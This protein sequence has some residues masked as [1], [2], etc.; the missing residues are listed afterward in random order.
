MI[1]KVNEELAS[2]IERQKMPSRT[3]KINMGTDSMG[4]HCDGLEAVKQAAYKAL[5][6]ERYDFLIYSW[7]YGAELKDLFGQQLTYVYA[8]VK[9]RIEEALLQDDRIQKV[10]DFAYEKTARDTLH[11]TFHVESSEGNFES[12]LSINV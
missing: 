7:N 3:Y 8:E 1:P 11:I 5:H 2:T 4:G 6:T 10:S 12:E 9:R